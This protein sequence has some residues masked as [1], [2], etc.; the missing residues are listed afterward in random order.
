VAVTAALLLGRLAQ[1]AESHPDS[2][3]C[4]GAVARDTLRTANGVHLP[5]PTQVTLHKGTGDGMVWLN[6]TKKNLW[7][8]PFP[9]DPGFEGRPHSIAV[10]RGKWS[11]CYCVSKSAANRVYNF[12]VSEKSKL[13][14]GQEKKMEVGGVIVED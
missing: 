5:F 14:H 6:Q 1:A 13:V 11:R 8:L 7:I 12:Y 10:P 3:L 4:A 2:C 9:A